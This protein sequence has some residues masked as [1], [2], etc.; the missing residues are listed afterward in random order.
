MD[1]ENN[2]ISDEPLEVCSEGHYI[3]LDLGH[4]GLGSR[5]HNAAGEDGNVMT[6]DEENYGYAVSV[7]VVSID[8][9][10]ASESR[11]SGR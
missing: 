4:S 8:D 6:S 3:I 1:Y 7:A 5:L 2:A 11:V 9:T 10:Q